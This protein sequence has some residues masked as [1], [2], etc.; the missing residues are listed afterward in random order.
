MKTTWRLLLHN[1]T[2][3]VSQAVIKK[4]KVEDRNKKIA[5]V[6]GKVREQYGNTFQLIPSIGKLQC[7]HCTGQSKDITRFNIFP[8][9]R[10]LFNN[11]ETHVSTT[12]HK[13]CLGKNKP[14]GLVTQFF[15]KA[16]P[17]S[18]LEWT[19]FAN[20]SESGNA[21]LCYGYYKKSV[22]YGN[23]SHDINFIY[24]QEPAINQ[25]DEPLWCVEKQ[26]VLP[27]YVSS[28]GVQSSGTLQSPICYQMTGIRQL[29]VF[30]MPENTRYPELQVS[31]STEIK[32]ANNKF[33]QYGDACKK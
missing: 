23:Q 9:R 17:D 33:G 18:W 13:K 21:T 10:N 16:C 28:L 30:R 8:E 14:Q 31:R 2:D 11:L 20:T 15:K 19:A 24:E 25:D 32:A 6:H 4:R 26:R 12:E 5:K 7:A 27:G 29:H 1:S 22:A 3:V